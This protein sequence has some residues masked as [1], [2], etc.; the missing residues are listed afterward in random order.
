MDYHSWRLNTWKT[1]INVGG[2]GGHGVNI[3]LSI[4]VMAGTEQVMLTKPYA[5][6][7]NLETA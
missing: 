5:D 2:R 6:F 1:Q 7:Y 3:P 4:I